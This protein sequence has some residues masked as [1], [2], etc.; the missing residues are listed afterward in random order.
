VSVLL[1]KLR[2]VPADEV[3]EIRQLLARND[4]AFFETPPGAWGIIAGGLWLTD[5]ARLAEADRLLRQYQEDR[6]KRAREEY[7]CRREK[8]E[9]ETFWGR[10][11]KQPF[12]ILL[13]IAIAALILYLSLRP[14]AD[15]AGG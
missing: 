5:D 15:L 4:V 9:V 14:F 7:A 3:E 11:R 12:Q 6:A 2:G 8:G 10:L 1:I 13:Y